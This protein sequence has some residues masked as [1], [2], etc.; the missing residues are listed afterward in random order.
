VF[1]EHTVYRTR[2]IYRLLILDG[3]SSHLTPEFDLFCTE[4]SIIT[5]CM[6]LHSL[7]LLQPCDISFFA[8]LKPLYGQQIQDY[9]RNRVN[10]I[11]KHDFLQVYLIVHTQAASIANI[12]SGFAATRLVAYNPERVLSKLHTQLKT[13]T[14]PSSSH[15]QA[16][17]APQP[18]NSRYL[19]ILHS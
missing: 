8:V 18:G 16:V 1:E 12:Q 11:D 17:Q 10:H 2:G 6:L 14:P 4:Y 13:P 7:H 3:H 5:L 15:A 19:M 9:M